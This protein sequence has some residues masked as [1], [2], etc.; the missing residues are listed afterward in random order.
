MSSEFRKKNTNN[1]S[2]L[3]LKNGD[4]RDTRSKG[5]LR[6]KTLKLLR[7]VFRLNFQARGARASKE[8]YFVSFLFS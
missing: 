4:T 3:A 5:R 8:L 2:E 6:D 7:L 1:V